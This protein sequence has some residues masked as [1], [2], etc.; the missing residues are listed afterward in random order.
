M[1]RTI[2]LNYIDGT[3]D[4]LEL[5]RAVAI[6]TPNKTMNLEELKDG[7]WRLIWTEGLIQ[8][9]SKLKNIE[10]VRDDS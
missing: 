1:K 4:D 9:F 6:K 7:T 5:S 3:F 8:D 10:V 2:R